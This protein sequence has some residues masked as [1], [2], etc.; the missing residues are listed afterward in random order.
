MTEPAKAVFLSYA[1]QDAAAAHRLAE[2]LRAR[3]VEVWLDT[4]E[5]RGGDVWDQKIQRQIKDCALFIPI[6]SHITDE[7]REGYFRLEWKLAVER[8]RLLSDRAAFLL[9]V[10]IDDTLDREADVP[11]VF[12]NVQWTRLPQG[13]PAAAFVERIKGLLGSASVRARHRQWSRCR[14][15]NTAW[16]AACRGWRR[17]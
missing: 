6:I 7:R 1:S 13:E 5:L 12:R 17:R 2:A 15:H 16:R 3:G 10:V 9:P 4:T 8:M 14:Y 11:D